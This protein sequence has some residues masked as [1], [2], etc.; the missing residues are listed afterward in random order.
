MNSESI[1]A[2]SNFPWERNK[3]ERS[4]NKETSFGF[5]KIFLLN[6][7]IEDLKSVATT[8]FFS[9]STQAPNNKH[10]IKTSILILDQFFN[11]YF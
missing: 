6:N 7:E 11:F 1:R 8:S 5:S 9:S 10:T 4:F 3:S 2:P